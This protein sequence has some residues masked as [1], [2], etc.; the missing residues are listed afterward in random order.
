MVFCFISVISVHPLNEYNDMKSPVFLS[1]FN[2]KYTNDNLSF[3]KY[4]STSFTIDDLNCLKERIVTNWEY[5][6]KLN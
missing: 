1:Y 6:I 3:Q 4:V 5:E 2:I